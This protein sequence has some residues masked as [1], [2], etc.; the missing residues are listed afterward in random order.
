M[1]TEE[2]F[3]SDIYFKHDTGNSAEKWVAR[4]INDNITWRLHGSTIKAKRL[5]SNLIRAY[6][7]S[8]ATSMITREEIEARLAV[9]KDVFKEIVDFQKGAYIRGNGGLGIW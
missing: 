5:I 3:L 7:N 2:S 8:S 4:K 6:S 9:L 1:R